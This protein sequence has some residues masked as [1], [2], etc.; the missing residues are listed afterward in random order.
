MNDDD[1]EHN[2]LDGRRFLYYVDC[3][4]FEQNKLIII[5]PREKLWKVH[6]NPLAQITLHK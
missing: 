6:D 1:D 2:D 5:F 4:I 3:F